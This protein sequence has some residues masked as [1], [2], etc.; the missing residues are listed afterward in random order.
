MN[1]AMGRQDLFGH[2]IQSF[3]FEP[4]EG[5][6]I[7]LY[8]IS[9][10]LLS[11][12]ENPTYILRGYAGTG[13][14]SLVK[15]L[16]KTLP[17]IGMRY[18]L[19]APTGRAAK[20]LSSYT[21]QNASTIHRKI[22]Q[23][24][25]FPDGSIRD[26]AQDPQGKLLDP[27]AVVSMNFWGFHPAIFRSLEDYL[28]RFLRGLAPDD[29]KSECLLPALVDERIHAGDLRVDV[30]HTDARWFGMTYQEDHALVQAEIARLHESGVYPPSLW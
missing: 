29:L 24:K 13:K 15:A 10:F 21:A 7:V 16:V 22:Y 30:L 2:L 17:S 14:T 25:T 4:T 5:Q 18:V 11:Q 20:V 23:A 26:T 1:N 9:A 3:G 12:K 6:S 19:M 8:H 27:E 28:E